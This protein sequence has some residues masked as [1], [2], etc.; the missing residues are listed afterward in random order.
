MKT[1]KKGLIVAA[2]IIVAV[3]VVL[4]VLSPQIKDGIGNLGVHGYTDKDIKNVDNVVLLAHSSEVGGISNSVAGFKEAVRL[5]A[6]AV[7]VD[8]CFKQDGT[9]VITD[10]Y[11]NAEASPLL[12]DV[13]KAMNEEKYTQTRLFLNVVQLTELSMLNTL[14][15]KYDVVSRLTIIGIDTDH[16]GLISSDDT[17][18][19]FYLTYSVTAQDISAVNGG[20]F[21]LPE[22]LATYGASGV[23]LSYADCSEKIIEA[24]DSYGVPTVIL[25]VD[26][27]SQLCKALLDN[28]QT[29]Y[30]KNISS[31]RKLLDSWTLK[32]QQRYE[33]SVE[34]SLN[35]LSTTQ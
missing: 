4:A 29:V 28:A 35:D 24:F 18:I 5:G 9:P 31:S 23:A 21:T 15:V 3:A 1:K 26:T 19:P 16:Y 13:F 32:M 12:E 22:A 11:E 27:G 34:Q 30:V 6:N 33:S 7:A 8:L 14:A 25:G 2:A 20:T 10:S 17:I